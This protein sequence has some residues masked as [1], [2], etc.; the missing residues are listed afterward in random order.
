M[1]IPKETIELAKGAAEWMASDGY[2]DEATAISDLIRYVEEN[3]KLWEPKER[4]TQVG[5]W[6][7]QYSDGLVHEMCYVIKPEIIPK[8]IWF[9]PLP[10]PPAKEEG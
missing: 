2:K 4:P 10:L 7:L 5:W 6:I 8:G 1:S 3:E 9:G